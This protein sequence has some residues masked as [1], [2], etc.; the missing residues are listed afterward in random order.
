MS[1]RMLLRQIRKYVLDKPHYVRLELLSYTIAALPMVVFAVGEVLGG[2]PERFHRYA[3]W[4]LMYVLLFTFCG[5][6]FILIATWQLVR[7][8]NTAHIMQ[9]FRS[10]ANRSGGD[11]GG[12]GDPRAM[13]GKEAAETGVHA[14]E[15][16]EPGSN[17]KSVRRK[18]TFEELIRSLIAQD[19]N[20]R[21]KSNPLLR[22]LEASCKRE[23][24][25]ENLYCIRSLLQLEE[26]RNRMRRQREAED[27]S[28]LDTLSQSSAVSTHRST[29]LLMRNNYRIEWTR[30]INAY[31]R[32][33]S[34]LEINMEHTIRV[35]VMNAQT[36]QEIEAAA[37]RLFHTALQNLSDTFERM[38]AFSKSAQRHLANANRTMM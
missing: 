7:L 35:Q 21:K 27:E 15:E 22:E 2:T 28:S 6:F 26:M 14:L 13:E 30:I 32:P 11:S 9:V 19:N 10:V 17:R 4:I 8:R 36:E 5:T 38:L 16:G 29:F 12:S 31:A 1:F 33:T 18:M 23:F 25:M 24:S 37:T 34:P 3:L 20:P